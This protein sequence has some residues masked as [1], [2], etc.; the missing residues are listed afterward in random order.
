MK[1]QTLSLWQMPLLFMLCLLTL[2]ACSGDALTEDGED[3]MPGAAASVLRVK[4]RA[5]ADGSSTE[6]VSFPVNIYVFNNSGVCAATDRIEGENGVMNIKLKRGS[7]RVYAIAGATAD[8]YDMPSADDVTPETVVSLK[9]G[10]THACLMTDSATVTLADEEDNT[11]TLALKR[12]VM[13]IQK[14]TIKNIPEETSGVSVT[15]APLYSDIQVNG[16]P[17]GKNA[18][19]TYTLS[20]EGSTTTW[21]TT[22]DIYLLEPSGDANITVT[23]TATDGTASS[24]SYSFPDALKANYKI[25]ITGSYSDN[26]VTLGG[27]VTGEDWA[28]TSD[29]EFTFEESPVLIPTYITDIPV[30]GQLY[31]SG[32]A[33]VVSA[34]DNGDGTKTYLLTSC[35]EREIEK[36]TA[37]TTAEVSE[38]VAEY[39]KVKATVNKSAGWRLPTL[40][41]LQTLEDATVSKAYNAL[42]TSHTYM[43]V[44]AN[45]DYARAYTDGNEI[46]ARYIGKDGAL[47][48]ADQN[49]RIKLFTTLTVK[50]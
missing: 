9:A 12:K 40:S 15:V 17:T 48:V 50:Q 27:T 2:C 36:G 21:S 41:E 44:L 29:V 31:A 37:T 28:G 8:N 1:K 30:V 42:R 20:R 34:T 16:Q 45:A 19:Q 7:Y 46:K 24:Y 22:S 23:L 38:A 10:K 6:T 32:E 35:R 18:A 5:A 47:N 43:G 11:L 25:N 4:A 49:T 14:V 33:F 13:L 26:T 3:G 39:I